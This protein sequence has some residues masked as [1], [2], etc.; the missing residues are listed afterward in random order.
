M[1]SQIVLTLSAAKLKVFTRYEAYQCR[2]PRTK[3]VEDCKIEKYPTPQCVVDP[4]E[5][6]SIPPEETLAS[7]KSQLQSV[8]KIASGHF[9]MDTRFGRHNLHSINGTL[10]LYKARNIRRFVKQELD[11]FSETYRVPKHI[12]RVPEK[13]HINNF[14]SKVHN[15][16]YDSVLPKYDMTPNE[17]AQLCLTRLLSGDH[18]RYIVKLLNSQQ[19]NTLCV[20]ANSVRDIKSYVGRH[21]TTKV[22]KLVV[23]LHIGK[24][25]TVVNGTPEWS[26][27]MSDDNN[28]GCHFAVAFVSFQ[29]NK[30]IYGD[31]LGWAAPVDLLS[32]VRNYSNAL[33]N[34]QNQQ[35][36]QLSYYHQPLTKGNTTH[37]CS[38]CIFEYPLQNDGN[39]CGIVAM[40]TS[41][42]FC[43]SDGKE[44]EIF[45]KFQFLSDPS[46]YNKFL[47]YVVITW[48]SEEKVD[49]SYLHTFDDTTEN[50]ELPDSNKMEEEND[51]EDVAYV[52]F[53]ANDDVKNNV[54]KSSEKPLMCDAKNNVKNSSEK[55]LKCDDSEKLIK[56]CTHCDYQTDKTSNLK[57][58]IGR[59][60][61]A[62]LVKEVQSTHGSCLC[63]ECGHKCFRIRDLQYHLIYS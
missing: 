52:D 7:W 45:Q 55:P 9:Y 39:I 49:L 60:H 48:F 47:R 5:Q 29:E 61:G 46:K 36:F 3:K 43:L 23:I 53:Q 19:G 34:H 16:S 44:E 57:R 30:I 35:S 10:Q 12:R 31:S 58:H 2:I 4:C 50:R 25:R 22:K 59:K 17:L 1:N 8:V 37:S 54:K 41:A 27:F 51:S 21:D 6:N 13:T 62:E 40:I 56:K 26:V 24:K 63:L 33:F 42:I 14:R 18:M 11:W 28:R 20:Y 32:L 15:Y 38:S